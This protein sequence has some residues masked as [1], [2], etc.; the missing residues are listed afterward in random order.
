MLETLSEKVAAKKEPDYANPLLSPIPEYNQF[1]S[2]FDLPGGAGD[3]LVLDGYR[4]VGKVVVSRNGPPAEF[5]ANLKDLCS[6]VRSEAVR[7]EEG[8]VQPPPERDWNSLSSR[9]TLLEQTVERLEVLVQVQLRRSA[10]DPDD[11]KFLK[12]YGSRLANVMGYF[13][14]EYSPRD[15]SQRWAEVV[16]DP[17]LDESL[18]AATGRPR[19][20]YVLYPWNGMEVLCEGSVIPYYEDHSKTILT[21]AEW[22]EKLDSPGAAPE[23][24]WIRDQLEV[25]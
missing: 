13:G 18:A 14:N 25:K 5:A 7:Y 3:L 23:P 9:W 15:D 16:R 20:L 4:G 8:Q 24:A 17:S 19:P 21:D 10:L 11:A 2:E 12:E 22:R 1:I 6:V